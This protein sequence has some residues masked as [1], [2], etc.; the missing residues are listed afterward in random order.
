MLV[1]G[2]FTLYLKLGLSF[3]ARVCYNDM[4]ETM[5]LCQETAR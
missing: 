4:N 2:S 3:F 1:N 5:Q